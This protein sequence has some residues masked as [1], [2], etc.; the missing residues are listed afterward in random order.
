M[1]LL[2]NKVTAS[3]YISNIKYQKNQIANLDNR[4]DILE[5]AEVST[6]LKVPD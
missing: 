6:F 3:I 4:T 5:T 2:P 1:N